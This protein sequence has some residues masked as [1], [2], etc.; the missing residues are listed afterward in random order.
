[1]VNDVLLC[2]VKITSGY[3]SGAIGKSPVTVPNYEGE[4]EITPDQAEH[5][6][7]TKG[8]LMHNDMS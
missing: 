6:L 4:Y 5:I 2:G 8:K 3:L 1:M 7:Q